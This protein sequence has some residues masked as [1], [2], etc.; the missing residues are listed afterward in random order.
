MLISVA[1]IEC[2]SY[3]PIIV[4]F[5]WIYIPRIAKK[6]EKCFLNWTSN[7]N[8]SH[9]LLQVWLYCK[10]HVIIELKSWSLWRKGGE[11]NPTKYFHYMNTVWS[12][13]L[14]IIEYWTSRA[15]V[16]CS[17][18]FVY[19]AIGDHCNSQLVAVLW[20]WFYQKYDMTRSEAPLRGVALEKSQDF[21]DWQKREGREEL[22]I[23]NVKLKKCWQKLGRADCNGLLL[24]RT[25][26]E[27][28]T[29]CLKE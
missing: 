15:V 3:P 16:T 1:L 2:S 18:K 9:S 13:K 17:R 7:K 26:G 4:V 6:F 12:L 23:S 24:W 21:K 14:E 27:A 8:I 25:G 11:L 10:Y 28:A 29:R 20:K 19:K 22:K 5:H